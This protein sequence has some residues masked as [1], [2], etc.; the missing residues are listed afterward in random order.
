MKLLEIA[1]SLLFLM[2][3]ALEQVGEWFRLGFWT[4]AKDTLTFLTAG[5]W[6]VML[7]ATCTII[8]PLGNKLA[9]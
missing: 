2:L 1:G 9:R 3:F 7:V 6:C 8:P 4:D 5:T